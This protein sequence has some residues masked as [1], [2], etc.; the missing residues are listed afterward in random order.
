MTH[1]GDWCQDCGVVH[2][3]GKC[4]RED[5][6]KMVRKLRAENA[7]WMAAQKTLERECDRLAAEK[8]DLLA[9]AH[10]VVDAAKEMQK[11]QQELHDLVLGTEAA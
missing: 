9:R 2:H 8:N 10:G 6:V 3:G 7:E 4:R 5:L 1:R 11:I